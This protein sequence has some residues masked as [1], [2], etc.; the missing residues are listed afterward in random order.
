M[1]QNES[2][3]NSLLLH[4][5]AHDCRARIFEGEVVQFASKYHQLFKNTPT[6]L[7]RAKLKSL[8]NFI[9]HYCCSP[10]SLHGIIK[11]TST[12]T[13]VILEYLC[14]RWE[15]SNIRA[16]KITHMAQFEKLLQLTA[17]GPHNSMGL[18]SFP[19][20]RPASCE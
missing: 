6:L 13:C 20:P 15:S 11:H 2:R 7:N 3:H 12:S 16:L 18:A 4:N 5:Q 17:H 19:G 14:V 9:P 8:C 10:L 1:G